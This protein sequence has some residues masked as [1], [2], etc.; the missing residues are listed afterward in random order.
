MSPRLMARDA[1][2][3]AGLTTLP[4]T[5]VAEQGLVLDCPARALRCGCARSGNRRLNHG[6]SISRS[7]VETS[8]GHGPAPLAGSRVKACGC[9]SNDLLCDAWISSADSVELSQ[10]PMP[11]PPA[12]VAN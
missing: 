10:R 5:R 3:P 6:L 7:A 8:G 9:R 2:S 12:L 4:A 1:G 11:Q